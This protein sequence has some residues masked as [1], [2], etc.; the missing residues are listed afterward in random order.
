MILCLR[1]TWSDRGKPSI[2]WNLKLS[3]HVKNHTAE[4]LL[5][6]GG[7]KNKTLSVS[8]IGN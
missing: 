7:E 6:Q 2:A 8:F 4:T 3:L 5:W 1:Q